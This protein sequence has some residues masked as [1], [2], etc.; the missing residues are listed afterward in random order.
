[1]A[2][3]D[4]ADVLEVVGEFTDKGVSGAKDKRPQLDR[5]MPLARRGGGDIAAVWKFDRFARSTRHLVTALEDFPARGIDFISSAATS[6]TVVCAVTAFGQLS[7]DP[8]P[9][10]RCTS[11]RLPCVMARV[12][13]LR[14]S[15]LMTSPS[16]AEA[17][18]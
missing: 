1:V 13:A 8:R 4:R 3:H 12:L 15:A 14:L 10:S 16:L 18:M 6:Q 17:F 7:A 9:R 11:W 5:L 2:I